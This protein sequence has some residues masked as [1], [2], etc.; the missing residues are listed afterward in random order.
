VQALPLDSF[1][2]ASIV[3]SKALLRSLRPE[4]CEFGIHTQS[5]DGASDPVSS[6]QTCN[7]SQT[8]TSQQ[9]EFT[10]LTIQGILKRSDGV[11]DLQVTV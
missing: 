3:P 4:T 5:N 6:S 10:I 8:Q 2:E 9:V 7:G 11:S 1:S